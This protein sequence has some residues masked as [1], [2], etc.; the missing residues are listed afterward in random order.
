MRTLTTSTIQGIFPSL[1]TEQVA[2]DIATYVTLPKDHSLCYYQIFETEKYPSLHLYAD[3]PCTRISYQIREQRQ[4][5]ETRFIR[6]NCMSCT[7][8]YDEKNY[9]EEDDDGA[10]LQITKSSPCNCYDRGLSTV[11]E[12]VAGYDL[13]GNEDDDDVDENGYYVSDEYTLDSSPLYFEILLEQRSLSSYSNGSD[14]SYIYSTLNCGV[15]K[16]HKIQAPDGTGAAYLLAPMRSALNTYG[17]SRSS[18]TA[19]GICWGNT[20]KPMDVHLSVIY[21]RFAHSKFNSDLLKD[22]EYTF[23]LDTINIFDGKVEFIESTLSNEDPSS[24]LDAIKSLLGQFGSLNPAKLLIT[25]D[26]EKIL[27]SDIDHKADALLVLS[28]ENNSRLFFKIYASGIPFLVQDPLQKQLIYLPLYAH[29][30]VH[31]A[32]GNTISGYVTQPNAQ[33]LAW[34]MAKTSFDNYYDLAKETSRLFNSQASQRITVF[35]QIQLNNSNNK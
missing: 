10:F 6:D 33:G 3:D 22:T 13:P 34:F 15:S 30:Y 1:K 5:T 18:M 9:D 17:G 8:Y 28:M 7:H 19:G 21:D 25:D 35:G 16:A 4:D 12:C 32:S 24:Y 26:K 14:L 11:E 20:D 2:P 29:D 23:S 31:E 27:L